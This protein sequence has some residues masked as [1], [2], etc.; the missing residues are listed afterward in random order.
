MSSAPAAVPEERE[1][2]GETRGRT[3]IAARVVE[4]I[5]TRALTEVDGVH[6]PAGRPRGLPFGGGPATAG[7][8]VR[9]RVDGGLAMLRMRIF[10]VYPAPL[11]QVTRSLRAHV[12]ARVGEL[13]GLRVRQVDIDIAGLTPPERA[14]GRPL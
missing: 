14:G 6:R 10:V 13:T 3:T 5:A 4:K 11:R 7:P 9:A 8:R 12:M 1:A 2:A